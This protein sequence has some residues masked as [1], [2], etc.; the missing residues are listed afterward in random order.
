MKQHFLLQLNGTTNKEITATIESLISVLKSSQKL[1][2]VD[3]FVVCAMNETLAS[4]NEVNTVVA[5]NE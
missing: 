4:S 3:S 2:Y 1:G 5:N